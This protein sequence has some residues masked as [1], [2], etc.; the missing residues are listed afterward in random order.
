MTKCDCCK[1]QVQHIDEDRLCFSCGIVHG[2]AAAIE[3]QTELSSDD[4]VELACHLAEL[5]K[6]RILE[7]G[8]DAPKEAWAGFFDD[9]NIGM[10]RV[11]RGH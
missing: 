2:F 3:K 7:R 6:S 11:A 9:V 4:A 10:I 1:E 5:V 8:K